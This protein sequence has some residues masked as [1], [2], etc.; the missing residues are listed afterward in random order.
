[1]SGETYAIVFNGGIVEGFAADT[2]K[3]Q[4]AKLLKTDAKKTSALFSGKQ[5][6]LK[7]TTDRAEAAKYG[8]ALKKVGADVKIRIIKAGAAATAAPVKPAAALSKPAAALSKPAAALSKPAAALSKPAAAP[9][10][11]AAALAAETP[12]EPEAP[13]IDTSGISLAPNEGDLFDPVPRA[14]I[15]EIDL[16]SFSVAENDDRPLVEPSAEVIVELDLSEFS[17]KDNDGTA[18]VEHEDEVIPAIEVPDFGLDEPGAVLETLQ[19][20][21]ELLNPSTIG[22]TLAIAG[23]ELLEDEPPPPPPPRAPDTSKINLVPNFDV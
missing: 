5:I 3:A 6:V 22:M 14:V 8:K 23:A 20:E 4:L 16:S 11:P 12:A 9:P 19:E 13:V 2:V 17:V 18:L 15:P 7:K 1:M 21:K 10:K